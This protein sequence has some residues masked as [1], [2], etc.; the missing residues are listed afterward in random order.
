MPCKIRLHTAIC[1]PWH[2]DANRIVNAVNTALFKL[3]CE[4]FMGLV[5][6]CNNQNTAGFFIQTVNNSRALLAEFH[7]KIFSMMKEGIYQSIL[8]MTRGRMNYQARGLI[9]DNKM[10]VFKKNI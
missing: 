1:R 6:F 7:R 2:P 10:F 5:V 4:F 3:L 9:N 8:R